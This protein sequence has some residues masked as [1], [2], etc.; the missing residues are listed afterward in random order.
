MVRTSRVI[1]STILVVERTRSRVRLFD[2][3]ARMRPSIIL[4]AAMLC[5]AV[6]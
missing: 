4:S 3:E 1:S 5:T 6:S 2:W